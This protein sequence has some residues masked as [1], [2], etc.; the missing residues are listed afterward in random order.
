MWGLWKIDFELND[1][2]DME[3]E[4]LVLILYLMILVEL[5][6]IYKLSSS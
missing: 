4:V 6:V 5:L 1:G 3:D 2:V